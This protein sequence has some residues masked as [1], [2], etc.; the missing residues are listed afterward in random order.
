MNDNN[1]SSAITIKPDNAK[2]IKLAMSGRGYDIE[3]FIRSQIDSLDDYLGN[4]RCYAEVQITITT[5]DNTTPPL[6]SSNDNGEFLS[7]G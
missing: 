4:G 1:E 2:K 5:Y 6:V 7:D 3:D